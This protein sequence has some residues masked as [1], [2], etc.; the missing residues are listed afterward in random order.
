M[1]KNAAY[2]I[3]PARYSLKKIRLLVEKYQRESA[4]LSKKEELHQP[5]YFI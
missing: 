1:E 4:L 5:S 2:M 3:N